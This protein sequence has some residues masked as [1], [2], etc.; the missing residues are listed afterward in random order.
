MKKTFLIGA[1]L[2]SSM[3]W[4]QGKDYWQQEV[5]YQMEIDVD[6]K[7]YQYDGSMYLTYTNNSPD[8]LDRV[9]FHLYF[10]AFQPGSMMDIRSRT[11]SDPDRRVGDRISKLGEDEIG[12]INVKD[13]RQDGKP[14]DFETVGTILEVDLIEPIQPGESTK[15]QMGWKAQVP[16]QVRRSGRTN[17][18]GIEFSMSQWYPKLCEYDKQGWHANPY[19]GRE[20]HGV[21]GDF[22]VKINIDK[23]YVV[24]AGAVLQ[25]KDEVGHGYSDQSAKAKKGKLNW[26]FLAENVHDFV[27]AADPDYVHDMVKDGDLEMHFFYQD[28]E[29]IKP[30]WK[31][32]QERTPEIFQIASKLFGEYPYPVYSI[33]QGGDGGMEYPMATL[34]TGK[35]KEK[36]LVGVT[37]HEAMHSWYQMILGTNEALYPWMDEGFT[38]Y[39]STIIMNE[40]YP[41][42][43]EPMNAHFRSYQSYLNLVKEGKDEAMDT[44]ADHYITNRAYGTNAYSKGEVFLKQL[45]YIIGEEDMAE[46]M[47]KYFDAW[48]F[49]HPTDKDFM[50][51]AE[52]VCGM[53][54]DWYHEYFIQSTKT[55]DYAI[56]EVKANGAKTEIFLERKGEMIMPLDV[57]IYKKDGT[58]DI[59]SIPLRIMRGEKKE[60]IYGQEVKLAPDWPWTHPGYVLSVPIPIADIEAIEIDPTLRLADT[61]RLNN[62]SGAEGGNDDFFYK[63]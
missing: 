47:L 9:F 49:K 62:I 32:L 24:G 54:L 50:R 39:A 33:I 7:N 57:M 31:I 63:E 27:W 29:A 26:H 58:S 11:I 10:N 34:I 1:L 41:P 55:I 38:S 20:F 42:S 56:G 14:L 2:M 23:D 52:K 16:L 21:W 15:F 48:K 13:L 3:I 5:L 37:V 17:A 43:E 8:V 53:E 19:I 60:S 22:D 18:E 44:H 46:T 36:S 59:Y 35:R 6:V 40:L 45:E 51:I 61:D 12:Y 28:D 25:N 4:G 30:N